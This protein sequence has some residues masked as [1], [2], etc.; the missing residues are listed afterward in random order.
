M[1]PSRF[2]YEAPRSL[3]EAVDLLHSSGDYTKVLAGGQSLVPMMK[4]RFAS[5]DLIVD[6]NNLP[7]LDYHNADADGTLHIGALCRHSDLEWSPL[8]KQ[9]QP[10][11]A[12]CAPL[13]AD[14]IVRNRGTLV[15][16]L[17]HADP[18]GDWAATMT[19]L[20]GSVVAH[21]PAGTR[22]IPMAEFVTGPFQNA[23]AHDEVAVEA[24]V[25]PA[26]GER[27]GGY[28]K[29]E[30]RVGDFA[31]VGVAVALELSGS[32]V[33]KAGI[34]LC[35][36]GGATINASAAANALVG[37]AL[38]EGAIENAAN[39]AVEASQPKSDHRGSAEY[40]R[41]MVGTFVVRLL[42]GAADP[43]GTAGRAA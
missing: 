32:T 3:D 23:L 25:P 31:T 17:C 33:A 28:L 40:K 10:T 35:G 42:Y 18:Q 37:Q 7:G 29:L 11:M 30:R 36:V 4:L 19:A 34:A 20:G 41:H 9:S 38:T 5:P 6:I 2:R 24:V 15:G 16:S 39:L 14:P 22:V 1:F 8:L 13:I 27:R 26:Q 21:G 43:Y 12:A